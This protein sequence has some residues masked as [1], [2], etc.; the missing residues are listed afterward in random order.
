MITLCATWAYTSECPNGDDCQFS[1]AEKSERFCLAFHKYEEHG[2]GRGCGYGE[3]CLF[4]HGPA[5]RV[6]YLAWYAEEAARQVPGAGDD[7]AP[8]APAANPAAAAGAA[9]MAGG[10]D[11]HNPLAA[12]LGTPLATASISLFQ[13]LTEAIT[14]STEAVQPTTQNTADTV[15]ILADSAINL[16]QLVEQKFSDFTL[17]PQL[18]NLFATPH[19]FARLERIDLCFLPPTTPFS[20]PLATLMDLGIL[21]GIFEHDF[22]LECYMQPLAQPGFC[23]SGQLQHIP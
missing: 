15:S 6:T 4:G 12:P 19:E 8:A 23:S 11:A 5:A 21:P 22:F 16:S 3:A 10:N 17:I 2:E 9:P 14:D 18:C 1:H 20:A 13:P 7:G